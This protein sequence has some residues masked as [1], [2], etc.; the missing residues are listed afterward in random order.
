MTHLIHH[1]GEAFF[2]YNNL[3]I[4][5]LSSKGMLIY[6]K[7]KVFI[8]LIYNQKLYDFLKESPIKIYPHV[9]LERAAT[10]A[11]GHVLSS[12]PISS[13]RQVYFSTKDF[14]LLMENL[15][16]SSRISFQAKEPSKQ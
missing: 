14:S 10:I 12:C 13:G 6:S 1:L 7:P 9:P 16:S 4:E 15:R 3:P 2:I 8:D 11:I 5:V